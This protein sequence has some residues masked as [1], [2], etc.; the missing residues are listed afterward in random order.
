MAVQQQTVASGSKAASKN[1]FRRALGQFPTGVTVITTIDEQNNPMGM[2]ASSFNSVSQDPP[3]ILWSID[4]SALSAPMF[5]QADYFTVNILSKDQ[6]DIANNFAHRSTDKFAGIAFTE[7]SFGCPVLE[8][9]TACLECKKWSVYEGGDHFIIVGEV[10]EYQYRANATPLVFSQSS[11]ALPVQNIS[12][13]QRPIGES[14]GGF[15]ENY[16]LYQLWSVYMHYSSNLYQLL[17]DECHVAPEEWRVLTLLLDSQ[18]LS[19]RKIAEQTSQPLNDCRSTLARMQANDH[20]VV[21]DKDL[22][23]I[24]EAGITLAKHL[25]TTANQHEASIISSLTENRGAELKQDLK[26][27]LTTL[28]RKPVASE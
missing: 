9:C 22:A 4:K 1:E 24:T 23:Q 10:L 7:G 20:L 2:T 3:L 16:L 21:D 8:D 18:A 14:N 13:T 19:V 15:L 11:Y 26:T 17:L 12:N 6:I 27:M 5:L 25:M 28:R